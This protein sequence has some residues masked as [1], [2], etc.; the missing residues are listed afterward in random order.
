MAPRARAYFSRLPLR[1]PVRAA[2]LSALAAVPFGACEPVTE[3]TRG[4]LDTAVEFTPPAGWRSLWTYVETCSEL[5][6]DFDA[7]RW[8]RVEGPVEAYGRRYHAA[9]L[10]DGPPVPNAIVF[11]RSKLGFD[12]IV[13]HEMLHA[14][15]RYPAGQHGPAFEACR[16]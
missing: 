10:P 5:T 12:G 2:A 8:Y 16:L 14:V 15:A 13:A 1:R 11:D 9:W 7:V 3:P 6:G 4:N